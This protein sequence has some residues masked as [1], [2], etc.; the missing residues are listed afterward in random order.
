MANQLWI[1]A[2]AKKRLDGVHKILAQ[3]FVSLIQ[4]E[5]PQIFT[6]QV[7]GID[8]R[9][10][11]PWCAHENVASVV[12]ELLH[13]RLLRNTT[14]EGFNAGRWVQVPPQPPELISDLQRDLP[15][16]GQHQGL[17]G[18]LGGDYPLQQN[19]A[20]SDGL[21]RPGLCLHDQ[22]PPFSPWRYCPQLHRRGVLHP[23]LIQ[24]SHDGAG[25]PQVLECGLQC[26]FR[27]HIFIAAHSWHG[28]GGQRPT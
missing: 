24:R 27:L 20:K 6:R 23:H 8:Q 22:V 12:S 25:D 17:L 26:L 19:G 21:P 5:E 2:D 4:H 16:G 9:M 3:E 10:D 1:V 15:G 14:Y 28:G 7:L 13:V 18:G 11:P